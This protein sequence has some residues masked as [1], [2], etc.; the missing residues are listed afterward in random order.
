MVLLRSFLI[1]VLCLFHINRRPNP[2]F[3]EICEIELAVTITMLCGTL[4]P[5]K[6]LIRVL[7]HTDPVIEKVAH[8]TFGKGI[9]LLSKFHVSF[10]ALLKLL[11]V[12]IFFDQLIATIKFWTCFII[13]I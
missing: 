1:P 5:V 4:R 13:C 2:F 8:L 9:A 3:I 11:C 10:K 7:L 12:P 6:R